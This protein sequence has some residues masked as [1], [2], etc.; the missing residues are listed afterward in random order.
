[1]KVPLSWLR[2]YVNLPP[3]N[4]LLPRLT[5]IGHMLE[6]YVQLPDGERVVSLEIRQNRPDCLS[7]FGI[8][9]EVAAAFSSPTREVPLADLPREIHHSEASTPDYVCFLHIRGAG[10]NRLPPEIL[11][12]LE[13][14]GQASVHP[15]VDLSN[16][17]MIEQG[18]PLHV[19]DASKVDVASAHSVKVRRWRF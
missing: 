18:Q 6:G 16:Y 2:Q 9:R 14:Y 11:A 5:E 8:A 17:V 12:M 19:Y 4:E 13:Q 3:E 15:F 10:L 7:I 1:M